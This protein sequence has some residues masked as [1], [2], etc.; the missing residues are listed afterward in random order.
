M[1]KTNKKALTMKTVTYSIITTVIALAS[2][3]GNAYFLNN[4]HNAAN[5]LTECARTEN[6][7]ACQFEAVPAE[8]PKVVYRTAELLP[9]PS[10]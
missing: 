4:A 9:P 1:G 6:V 10:M 7:F 2:L 5:A 8:A 3:A